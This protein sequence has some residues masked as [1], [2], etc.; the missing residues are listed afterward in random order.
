[1][2]SSVHHV[3]QPKSIVHQITRIEKK[4]CKIVAGAI[5]KSGKALKPSLSLRKLRMKEYEKDGDASLASPS[6]SP[7]QFQS[8]SCRD[9][10]THSTDETYDAECDYD[11]DSND[12]DD[13]SLMDG[14]PAIFRSNRSLSSSDAS[15]K[16]SSSRSL[17]DFHTAELEI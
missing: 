17:Y 3:P 2:N 16:P 8:K 11:Y 15:T 1:M 13:S 12:D 14:A 6:S 7:R 9:F 4:G 10:S 5:R